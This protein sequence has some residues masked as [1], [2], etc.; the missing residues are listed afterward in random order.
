MKEVKRVFIYSE[1]QV[2]GLEDLLIKEMTTKFGLKTNKF[3]SYYVWMA[4]VFNVVFQIAEYY[5]DPE[6]D[7]F[8]PEELNFTY[9][10]I[11]V[12]GAGML[13]MSY[14]QPTKEWIKACLLL[15]TFRQCIWIY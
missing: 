1:E 15:A 10:T 8:L 14:R 2:E 6:I 12:I 3:V 7:T 11:S 9:W 13:Y 4:Q 5:K